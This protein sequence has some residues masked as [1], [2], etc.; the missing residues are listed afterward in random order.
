[1]PCP[2]LPPLPR[3]QM[4]RRALLLPLAV[5][6]SAVACGEEL[7]APRAL[8]STPSLTEAS[9]SL[10]FRQVSAGSSQTCG[11]TTT[12]RAYCWG[13]GALRPVPVSG[14]RQYLQVSVGHNRI[15]GITTT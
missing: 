4:S 2:S 8:E 1:M 14:G 3:I 13:G 9:T 7:T 6:V 11:V 12:Y 10:V 15:C 5:T